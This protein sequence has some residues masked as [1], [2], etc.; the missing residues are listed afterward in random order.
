MY[1]IVVGAGRIGTRVVELAVADGHDV[2]VF[3][4]DRERCNRVTKRFDVLAFNADATVE[5]NLREAGVDEADALIAATQRD[6][7]NLMVM[8]LAERLG[9]AKRVSV[10]NNPAAAELFTQHGAQVVDNPSRVAA[11]H[12]LYA[13]RHPGVGSYVPVTGGVQLIK[14]DV[15]ADSPVDGVAIKNAQLPQ[16]VIVAAVE[17][18]GRFLLP[19]GDTMVY[20]GDVVTLLAKEQLVDSALARFHARSAAT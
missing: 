4:T 7:V 13:A 12:L 19:R 11:Q 3:D 20:A 18:A 1:I 2:G 8:S 15:E 9:V 17:R 5:S 6:P 16:G 14:A 10:L